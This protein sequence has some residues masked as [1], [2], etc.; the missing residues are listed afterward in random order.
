[1]NLSGFGADCLKCTWMALQNW[2]TTLNLSEILIWMILLYCATLYLPYFTYTYDVWALASSPLVWEWR[3]G[4]SVD[5]DV[6]GG[7]GVLWYGML[8]M[9]VFGAASA[10]AASARTETRHALARLA[11]CKYPTSLA[12]LVPAASLPVCNAC[13]MIYASHDAS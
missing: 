13:R 8:L 10:A 12:A 9:L 3:K 5:G 4:A 6:I 2:K 7:H 11:T 1:M